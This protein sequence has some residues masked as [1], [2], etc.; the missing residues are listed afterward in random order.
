MP[1]VRASKPAARPGIRP[2]VTN[3]YEIDA[4]FVIY[5]LEEAGATLLALP[6][7]GWST[8]LR[9]SSLEIVRTA[10]ESYGW[11]EARI[12]P[13][14][15]SAEKITRMDEALSWIS[16][17]PLDRYVLRRIV[18]ARSLVHPITDRHLFPWRRLGAALGADHKAVQRWHAQGIRIIV[19]AL[20][21]LA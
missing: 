13:V 5:R 2:V 6:N 11:T 14:T 17:I 4:D 21:A 10:L 12:R 19:E 18:G 9:S 16:L 3:G 20:K 7:T 15:P 8:R 1:T